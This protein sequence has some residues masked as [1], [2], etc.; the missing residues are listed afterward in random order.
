VR[1]AKSRGVPVVFTYHT[2][3][4][5]CQRGTLLLW[6]QSFCDGK[7]DVK[8]CAGC[9]LNGLGIHRHVADLVGRLSPVLGS[10]LGDLGLRGGIWTALRTSELITKRHGAF[11]MMASEV[12]HIVAVCDWVYE[13]LLVN[14]IPAAK[15]SVSRQGISWTPDRTPAP[16]SAGVAPDEVRL[17]FIGRLDSTKGLHVLINAFRMV[18]TLKVS[19][20]VYGIV[21]SSA[22]AAYQKEMFGLAGGDSRISFRDPIGSRDVVSVLR[23]YDFLAVPSLWMETGPM[24][25][26]EAFAAGIPVIGANL[27]GI[28]EI[29]RDGVDGLLVEYDSAARWAEILRRVSGDA[30]Q[31]AQL[32][33]G[34][35]PPRTSVQVAR[36]ML[37]LYHTLVGTGR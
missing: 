10:R 21:Q 31:R 36:E 28:A 35:R 24:V 18:S 13:L 3:T 7:L 11:H 14:D 8:R 6:G 37:G 1:A 27:G 16:V 15:V 23:H 2:P 17:A 30:E 4:V 29:V 32:K 9:T 12:D 19:L 26:L 34:V 22:N 25:V 33:A 5:S 20:H